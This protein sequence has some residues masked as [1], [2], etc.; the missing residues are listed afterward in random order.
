MGLISLSLPS[1][2]STADVADVNTPLT[3]IA[4]EL[5][6]N[7]DNNNIKSGAAIDGAKLADTS[8]DLVKMDFSSFTLNMKSATNSTVPTIS[9]GNNNFTTD[10]SVSFTVSHA[11]KAMVTANVAITSSADFEMKPI[12][13]L[14]NVINH[15]Y[16][17]SAAYIA[18]NRAEVRSTTWVVDLT[19]GAHTIGPGVSISAGAGWTTQAGAIEIS[20]IVLGNVTA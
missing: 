13:Y 20:A 10:C 5:N 18:S 12:I 15:S 4:T 9:S 3:T 7:L 1:D 2:G 6:G 19:A 17:P 11:C 14:D 8:I 16:N